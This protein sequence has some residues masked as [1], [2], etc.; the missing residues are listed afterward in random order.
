MTSDR[1]NGKKNSIAPTTTEIESPTGK[2]R[3][4]ANPFGVYLSSLS[5]SSRS[6]AVWRL[7]KASA[8]LGLKGV[9]AWENLRYSDLISLRESASKGYS[10]RT[11]SAILHAVRGVCRQ[12]W[13][14]GLLEFEDFEKM[15]QIPAVKGTSLPVGRNVPLIELQALFQVCSGNENKDVR[16]SALLAILFGAGLRR[17][18]ARML[19]VRDLCLNPTALLVRKGKGSKSRKVPIGVTTQSAI[20]EWIKRLKEP[21]P[22]VR[23][24]EK[25]GKIT[26]SAI[27][28]EG[29]R[30][31]L[32]LLAKRAGIDPFSPHDCRRTYCSGLLAG[33]A[34]LAVVS[35][36]LGHSTTAV[37]ANYDRRGE[38]A[39]IEAASLFRLPYG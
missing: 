26:M 37:T 9:V 29:L 10:Y 27:S 39:E 15:R 20:S 16:D 34:D 28:G 22:I 6:T 19:D 32:L 31:R 4:N 33:G 17:T 30:K 5:P 3:K 21:G 24:L 12:A 1:K 38:I 13:L 35:R 36:L 18:E 7:E 23:R 8:L 11:A 14:L 25:S 2:E